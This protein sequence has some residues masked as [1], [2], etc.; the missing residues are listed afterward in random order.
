MEGLNSGSA[1]MVA[2][3]GQIVRSG[4]GVEWTAGR[5]DRLCAL[6]EAERSYRQ[7]GEELGVSRSSVASKVSALRSYN[8]PRLPEGMRAGAGDHACMDCGR[9][10]SKWSTG[11]CHSCARIVQDAVR[12]IPMPDGFVEFAADKPQPVLAEHY[13]VGI[14]TVARWFKEAGIVRTGW[15]QPTPVPEDLAQRAPTH[16]I[17][18]LAAAYSVDRGV[19]RRWLARIGIRSRR[20]KTEVFRVNRRPIQ[21][22]ARDTSRAGQAAVFL[23]KW[24]PVYRCGP[25]GGADVKGTHWSRNGYILTDDELISRA[26]RLGWGRETERS[27]AA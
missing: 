25:A 9:S 15:R 14:G 5:V 24:G 17:M 27:L 10:V 2:V 21:P 13:G 11:R 8:D 12:Q 18:E 7:I 1:T 19:V 6:L 22:V 23:Q 3:P 16:T 26:E 20:N 4:R